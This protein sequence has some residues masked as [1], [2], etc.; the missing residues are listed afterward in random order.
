MTLLA[1]KPN[2]NVYVYVES[3]ECDKDRDTP[4]DARTL[5]E[6]EQNS[7]T[8]IATLRLSIGTLRLANFVVEPHGEEDGLGRRGESLKTPETEDTRRPRDRSPARL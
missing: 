5:F 8:N 3:H 2:A 4:N 6:K 7:L 1:V